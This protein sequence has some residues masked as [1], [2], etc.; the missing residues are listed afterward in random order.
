MGAANATDKTIV[1]ASFLMFTFF[2]HTE[3]RCSPA[4]RRYTVKDRLEEETL[5]GQGTLSIGY[6][7]M[8]TSNGSA[9]PAKAIEQQAQ[10]SGPEVRDVLEDESMPPRSPSRINLASFGSI[11]ISSLCGGLLFTSRATASTNNVDVQSGRVSD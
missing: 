5:I 9:K 7:V 2:F 11:G 4:L 1:I 8:R 3:A 10:D 6:R